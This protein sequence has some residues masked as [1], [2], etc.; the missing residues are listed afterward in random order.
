M[1]LQRILPPARTVFPEN[2]GDDKARPLFIARAAQTVILD[3][4]DGIGPRS[5]SAY[6]QL[7]IRWFND[8]APDRPFPFQQKPENRRG[9]NPALA[10][11]TYFRK[12]VGNF[13]DA[14]FRDLITRPSAAWRLVAEVRDAADN[15]LIEWSLAGVR[16]IQIYGSDREVQR[17]IARAQQCKSF[18]T[19]LESAEFAE[20]LAEGLVAVPDHDR[21]FQLAAR[22]STGL[23]S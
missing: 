15:Y 22:I 12:A 10:R 14:F 9:S 19:L 8:E 5:V 16:P 18:R 3:A 4:R 20:W 11:D 7:A 13:F 1:R 21:R 2:L 6:A 23:C 17:F